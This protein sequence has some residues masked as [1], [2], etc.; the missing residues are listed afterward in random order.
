MTDTKTLTLTDFL[1]ARI[2]EDEARIP[3]GLA[4]VVMDGRTRYVDPIADRML[5]ECA[6]KRRIVGRHNQ[7]RFVHPGGSQDTCS[8]CHDGWPCRDL[9][10]IAAVYADHPDHLDEWAV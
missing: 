9:R 8:A 3:E 10:D 6:A 2:A 5:A 4:Q 7:R 1:L